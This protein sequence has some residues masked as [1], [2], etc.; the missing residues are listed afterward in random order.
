MLVFQMRHSLH[1]PVRG[2]RQAD[3]SVVATRVHDDGMECL[4]RPSRVSNRGGKLCIFPAMRLPIGARIGPYEI[5][6]ALGA[7]GM[8]EVYDGAGGHR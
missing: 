1:A 4:R 8:G 7:G 3:G 5:T 6:G 2:I